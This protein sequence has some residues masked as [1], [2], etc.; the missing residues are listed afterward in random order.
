[1]KVYTMTNLYIFTGLALIILGAILFCLAVYMIA[2]Y[3]KKLINKY[4]FE[5]VRPKIK[6]KG[7][8]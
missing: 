5:M 2:K 6:I 7:K 1:M 3:E 8:K 4:T